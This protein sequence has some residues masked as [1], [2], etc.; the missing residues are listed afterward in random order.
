MNQHYDLQVSLYLKAPLLSSGGEDA[1]RGLSRRFFRNAQD[2]LVLPGSHV[3]GKLKEALRELLP[4]LKQWSESDLDSWFGKDT[5]D[6]PT[7][8]QHVRLH[9]SDFILGQ[10]QDPRADQHRTHIAINTKTGTSR[11]NFLLTLEAL[12]PSGTLTEWRGTISFFAADQVAAEA[13]RA[14]LETGLR[15]IT[16]MGGIKGSGYGRLEK[17]TS[18]L[19][20]PKP[21]PSGLS[22][23]SDQRFYH[24][25]FEFDSDLFVGGVVNKTNYRESQRVIPGAVIK[26]ALAKFIN[27]LCGAPV[28]APIDQSNV[29][30]AQQFEHLVKAFANLRISHAFPAPPG[31]NSRPVTI[32]LSVVKDSQGN[33]CDVALCHEAGIDQ[34]GKAPE[35]QIDWKDPNAK[36]AD[37]GWAQC[38]FVNKTRTRIEPQTRTAKAEALYTFQY[39][40]PFARHST[41]PDEAPAQRAD[42]KEAELKDRSTAPD[43]TSPARI[44]WIA[45]VT[46]PAENPQEIAAELRQALDAGWCFLGKR[47]ARF[48]VAP[49]PN[50]APAYIPQQEQ[51]LL[52]NGLAVIS[53]QTEALLFDAYENARNEE[54]FDVHAL[55]KKY[56]HEATSGACEMT[57]VFFARQQFSGGYV[58]RQFQTLT[59]GKYYPFVL[60]SAGS[61]FVLRAL[62]KHA[63]GELKKLH[64]SGLPLPK[65][66]KAKLAGKG[67][68]EDRIWQHCPFVPENGFGEININ[69][70]WHWQNQF[71]GQ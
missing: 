66:I 5:E 10:S 55:Y 7:H 26:G 45:N 14:K 56:W 52:V 33:Y 50:H 70:K 35:F 47:R 48:R 42:G 23:D 19:E 69:L 11:E 24:L 38:T 59:E 60:T 68:P 32:P 28:Q 15:W 43:K 44:R 18:K 9:F 1:A 25:I 62:D 2:Q 27:E 61:V 65:A 64:E 71:Q 34:S 30:V 13:M 22:I 31:Q 57:E 36:D 40:S 46:L 39:L 6:H 16:A 67:V 49:R 4:L 51:G 63:H 8:V 29:A 21:A 12:F 17:V 53:L 54:V 58:A 41:T 20:T 37:F 3:K